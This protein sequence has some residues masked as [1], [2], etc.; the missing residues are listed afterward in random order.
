MSEKQEPESKQGTEIGRILILVIGVSVIFA[1][2]KLL[3]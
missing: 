3:T 1:I 2:Y